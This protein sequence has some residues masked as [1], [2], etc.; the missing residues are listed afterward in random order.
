MKIT[1]K[2]IIMLGVAA[3]MASGCAKQVLKQDVPV[4]TNPMGARIYA[5]GQP[6]GTTPTTVSLE[7]NRN[8]ILTLTKDSYRQE[9]VVIE[10]HY[11]KDRVYLKAIESGI[12]SGLFFK[13]AAMGMG[14]G[15]NAVSDQEETGEAYILAPS[16][17]TVTL[18]PLTA[19]AGT[20]PA[21]GSPAAVQPSPP[22][23]PAGEAQAPP[24]ER[25]E[26]A[27]E[28]LMIGA[29]AA[30]TAHPLEK[31]VET[32]SSTKNYVTSDGTHVQ[33]KTSTSVGVGVNPA[34]LV[35]VI[36]KLFK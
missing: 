14:S 28:V 16:A 34:G 27:R 22:N 10:R 13:N 9:D 36:D 25:G 4:T 5:N 26:L 33:E 7:R 12:N 24:M 15:M 32:S 3:L 18:T 19:P 17:V 31:K 20:S 35:S 8:H 6:M 1:T 2:Q 30:L 29:G 11:Q 21:M 23:R